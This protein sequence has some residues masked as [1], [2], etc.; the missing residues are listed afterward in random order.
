MGR[1][2]R[3]A[4][5]LLATL[6]GLGL[7]SC[8][9]VEKPE[10][11]DPVLR[12]ITAVLRDRWQKGYMTEDIDLYMSAYWAEGFLY[13]SDMGTDLDTTD[14]VIFDDITLERESAL[15][16]FE[17]FQ[18]IEIELSEPPEIKPLNE[19]R[20]RYEVRNHYRIQLFVTEGTL[21]GGYTGAF[22]EGD[23][24]FIFE[25]RVNPETGQEEWR[26]VEWWDEAFTPEE[27]RAANNL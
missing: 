4:V 27:I 14:D 18:D 23:N 2:R 13:R 9:D 3:G 7:W 10:E 1:F 24:R 8:G 22:A 17:R 5:A 19:E 25:K 20:T 11:Q 12:E 21:E 16:I 26:I 6:I 15:R